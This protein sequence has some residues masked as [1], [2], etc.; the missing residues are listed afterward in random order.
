MAGNL[1]SDAISSLRGAGS[2]TPAASGS[3]GGGEAQSTDTSESEYEDMSVVDDSGSVN[4]SD[5][6]DESNPETE[7]QAE[8]GE[9]SDTPGKDSTASSEKKTSKTPDPNKEVITVTDD[10]GKRKLEIDYSD[11]AATRKAHEM[12]AAARKWQADRDR[13]AATRK[14]IEE[15]HMA[16][17]KVLNALEEAYA[18]GGELAVIDLIA[19]KQGASAE[20]IQRQIDRAKFLEKASPAEKAALEARE[21]LDAQEREIAKLRKEGE[22]REQRIAAEREAAELASTESTV[23]PVFE[24]YRFDGKLGDAGDEEMFDEMLWNTA[25]KRLKPYEDKGLPMTK[26]LVDREFRTVATQLRKRINVQ[27]EK[28]AAAVVEQKKQEATENAQ[29]STV[30]AYSKGGMSAERNAMLSKGDLA[31]YFRSF[32]SGKRK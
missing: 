30:G 6:V 11:R 5:S 24:K 17:R 20:F 23:H 22:T 3:G 26:E 12:A 4:A 10:T 18:S 1:I 9:K 13:E 29:A 16:D 21:R 2:N 32:G 27:A 28:R 15:A 7:T 8:S 19:G 14:K 31:G 25:L